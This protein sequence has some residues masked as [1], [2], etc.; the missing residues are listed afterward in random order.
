MPTYIRNTTFRRIGTIDD[1]TTLI[2]GFAAPYTFE[3]C[4][5]YGQIITNGLLTIQG[6]NTTFDRCEFRNDAVSTTDS[7][8]ISV[9]T[10]G[11]GTVTLSARNS[12]FI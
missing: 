9:T 10:G 7:A 1:T 12:R 4:T 8:P 2:T 6:S 3:G 11:A 5:F